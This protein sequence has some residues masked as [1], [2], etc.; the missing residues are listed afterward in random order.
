[1]E[2]IY[3]KLSGERKAAQ[4][5]GEFPE[6]ATTG[7]YQMFKDKY[8]YG[9]VGLKD[10]LKRIAKTLSEHAVP[11]IRKE[12]PLYDRITGFHGDNWNDCF[13]SIM[14]KNHFQPSTPVLANTNP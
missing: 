13:F 8:E 2:D 1:M 14:W 11:F 9:V 6:W 4:E 7:S 12:H 10:Q 5:R 3:E